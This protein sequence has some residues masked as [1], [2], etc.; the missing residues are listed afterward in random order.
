MSHRWCKR[1]LQIELCQS[2]FYYSSS[3]LASWKSWSGYWKARSEG[4]EYQLTNRTDQLHS[5]PRS[6][7]LICQLPQFY[8]RIF[9]YRKLWMRSISAS[10][11]RKMHA[12]STSRSRTAF[13]KWTSYLDQNL[14]TRHFDCHTYFLNVV[15]LIEPF[16]IDWSSALRS[17]ASCA[18]YFRSYPQNCS[19][20]TWR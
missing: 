18:H 13:E 12:D 1:C 11:N 5:L 16:L 2:R 3:L 6:K 9:F 7:C 17:Y 14:V 20:G 8:L 10:Q 19:S 15:F 4:L